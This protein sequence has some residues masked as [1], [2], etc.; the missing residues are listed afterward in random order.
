MQVHKRPM[1]ALFVVVGVM[2]AAVMVQR[3]LGPHRGYDVDL[4]EAGA[5]MEAETLRVG[6]AKRNITPNLDAYD[7]YTDV[8]DSGRYEPHRG[9]TYEDRTRSGRFDPV[10]LGGFSYNRPA[11]D[12]NDPLWARAVALRNNG[13]TVVLVSL[14][15]VGIFQDRFIGMRKALD[16]GLGVD[17]VVFSSTHTHAA[18]DT[19][20]LWSYQYV[21]DR[22]DE[23]Y[24][25]LLHGQTVAAIEEAVRNL[26]PAEAHYAQVEI[27]PEGFVRDSRKP[28]V[29]DTVL[30]CIRFTSQDS[31]DTIA[32][33]M[34]WG[35]HPEGL[36]GSNTV[37]TSDFPHYW[38]EAVENGL[39]EPNGMEGLGGMS[40]FFQGMC[41]G[42]MTP[43]G[44][45]VP[46][47]S[48]ER[49]VSENTFEK[50]K[51]LGENLAIR[52]VEA[53]TGPDVRTME[54]PRLGFAGKTVY[55]PIETSHF[56]W[57][58]KLGVLHP[59]WFWGDARTEIN[60]IRLGE[61]E[62]LTT[63]GELYPEIGDGGV[64]SPD[65]A[66]FP[67]EPVEIPPLREAMG[68]ELNLIFGLANDAIGY[69]I[70]K[71]Q[72]DVEPPHAYGR[73]RPQYGESNSGGPNVAPVLHRES[74][75]LLQRFHEAWR[76]A[77]AG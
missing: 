32:T 17:H 44:I 33:V 30:G 19:M 58:V 25:A 47:R 28:I 8:S 66:D 49:S 46:H 2:I 63:P 9:D 18:P 40:V 31:G 6:A 42:L 15:S 11:T 34:N 35:N 21:I 50:A 68:G 3:M 69:I 52:T 60:V 74:L 41:G 72:W 20:G 65:G 59:G 10:W 43:L 29:Y 7:V 13:V 64:E 24:M 51:Y 5:G 73:D 16:P 22:L 26:E 67:G 56:R 70:P 39:P 55:V 1:V 54:R 12:V 75:E 4:V 62:I 57:A 23:A 53:L 48:G 14:D 38:R 71:T 27:A 45:E 37:I 76:E 61:V 77:E 36:D